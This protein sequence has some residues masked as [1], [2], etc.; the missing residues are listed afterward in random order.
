MYVQGFFPESMTK[1]RMPDRISV[2]H[3]DCD[4]YQPMKAGLEL[5]YP[6]LSPGGLMLLHDYTSGHWP[7]IHQA[8][9]EF[10]AKTVEKP[11]LAPDKSGTA[12]VRKALR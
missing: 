1:I 6:R 12:I 7:G 2:V 5:F 11:V 4:L 3:I 9:D 10:F 8:I